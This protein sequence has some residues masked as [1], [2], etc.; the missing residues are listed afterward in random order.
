MINVFGKK[1]FTAS[2]SM[3]R[4]IFISIVTPCIPMFYIFDSMGHWARPPQETAAQ[5]FIQLYVKLTIVRLS[6]QKIC[7]IV[8]S[9]FSSMNMILL[10]MK[11]STFL[12]HVWQRKGINFIATICTANIQEPKFQNPSELSF[13]NFINEYMVLQREN[14]VILLSTQSSM[15]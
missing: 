3:L 12:I 15:I 11:Y 10:W 8:V 4:R 1:I 2:G 7:F 13:G 9:L 14:I 5:I 6:L